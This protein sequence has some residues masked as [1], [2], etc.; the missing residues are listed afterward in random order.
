M[1]QELLCRTGS[2]V[3]TDLLIDILKQAGIA[4][5]TRIN[6]TGNALDAYLGISAYGDEIFVMQTQY[7][8]AKEIVGGYFINNQEDR[9]DE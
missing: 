9:K 5:A 6:A 8:A 1:E 3:E 7:A 4:T 2:Q